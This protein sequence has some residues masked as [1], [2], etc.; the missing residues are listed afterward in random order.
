[1]GMQAFAGHRAHWGAGSCSLGLG[2]SEVGPGQT[3]CLQILKSR[4]FHQGQ[5]RM[6]LGS[7]GHPNPKWL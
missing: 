6:V 3:R 5:L 7:L 1:M 2:A 4:K